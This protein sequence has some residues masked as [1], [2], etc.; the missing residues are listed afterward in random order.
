[1]TKEEHIEA[2]KKLHEALVI[3]VA[4]FIMHTKKLPSETSISKLIIWCFQ[5]TISQTTKGEKS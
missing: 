5:Q 1:M 3:L 2:H 4:D